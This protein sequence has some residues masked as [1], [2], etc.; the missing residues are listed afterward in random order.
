MGQNLPKN[1][2][3][4]LFAKVGTCLTASSSL[5]SL[6]FNETLDR[7][8]QNA[9]IVSWRLKER[10]WAWSISSKILMATRTQNLIKMA[11][12][13]WFWRL[14]EV[15]NVPL[16]LMIVGNYLYIML[17]KY[18]LSI[19]N[20]IIKMLTVHIHTNN[21]D[22]CHKINSTKVWYNIRHDAHPTAGEGKM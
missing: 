1:Q 15:K 11:R 8:S 22:N 9:E 19:C 18:A 17:K 6:K 21:W 16:I 10:R 20:I 7:R 12:I 13:I 2:I 3:F 14:C 4:V 5:R